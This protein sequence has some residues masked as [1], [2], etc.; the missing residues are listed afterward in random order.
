LPVLSDF[1][2]ASSPQSAAAIVT[3]HAPVSCAAI[4]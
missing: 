4:R 1:A 3:T 2:M